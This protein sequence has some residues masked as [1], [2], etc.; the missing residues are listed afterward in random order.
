LIAAIGASDAAAASP[1]DDTRTLRFVAADVPPTIV[2]VGAPGRSV[3]DFTIFD[4]A[5]L[6]A[7]GVREV[8]R[9]YGTQ[10][11]IAFGDRHIVQSMITYQLGRGDTLTFGGIG[12]Y[13]TDGAGLVIGQRFTR[14]VLGGTGRYA[15]ARGT[16]TTIRREDGSYEQKFRIET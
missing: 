7:R 14:P 11:T 2:D 5:V 10:T 13:P 3:G 4:G 8:G 16:V 15:G 9:Y 12:E 6:D 1:Q